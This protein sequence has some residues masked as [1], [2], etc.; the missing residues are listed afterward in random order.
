MGIEQGDSFSLDLDGLENFGLDE[1][2]EL[3]SNLDESPLPEDFVPNNYCVLCGKGKEYF[4]FIGNRRFRT[5]VA[6]NL[7]RYKNTKE[8]VGKSVIVSEVM[9]VVRNA[10]GIFCRYDQGAWWQV[11]EG[12]AREKVGALF[13][14]FLHT[15]Y[16]SSGKAKVEARRKAKLMSRV[17]AAAS[18]DPQVSVDFV[19][20]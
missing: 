15:K 10:G 18:N 16:R 14:D 9:R 4:D 1:A 19:C 20:V 11:T 8:K 7:D 17:Q 13:R 2:L 12:T 6:M 5:I 3:L